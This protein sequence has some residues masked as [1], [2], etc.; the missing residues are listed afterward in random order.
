[1][2]SWVLEWAGDRKKY[3][4]ISLIL[5]VIHVVFRVM[6]FFMI[7]GIVNLFLDGN[8][9]ME[10]YLKYVGLIVVAYFLSELMHSLSTRMS[11]RATF[12][13]L[14]G[15]RRQAYEKLAKLPLGYVKSRSSGAIKTILVE[16]VDSMETLMAHVVPEFTSNI[17]APVIIM[18]YF[19]TI[20]YRMALA[21]LIPFGVGLFFAMGMS[22]G[23]GKYYNR[24]LTADKNL[25]AVS[26]EYIDGI[27]V[28]KAF[29][30]TK[31]SYEKFKVAAAEAANSC[32]DW[33]KHCIFYQTS[34]MVIMPFMLVAVLPFGGMFVA[35]GTLGTADFVTCVICS[36]SV[37]GPLVTV[38]SYIDDI[39][40]AS[41]IIADVT[42]ILTQPEL[43]RPE[44]SKSSPRDNSVSL[45]DV[46]FGYDEQEVLHGI[47]MDIKP[48]TVNALVGPSGTGKSTVAK[49]IASFWDVSSGS[50]EIG[51]VNIKDIA[52][53]DYNQKIAY[54]AQDNFLFNTSVRENIRQGKPDAT[55]EEVEEIAKKSG[56]YEFIMS[57]EK[58]FDTIAG[59]AG[60]HLSGG[61]RQR[62]SIARAMLK[63]AP[64]I[65]LDE[66]TAYTDPENEA[67]I[68]SSIAKLIAG[69]TLIVIAHRLSTIKDADQIFVINDGKLNAQGTHGELL[70]NCPLYKDMWEAHIQARD[71]KEVLA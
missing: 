50:I 1:M 27:E 35:N 25:D 17:L 6:P 67:I 31:A 51:G 47:T 56:C 42:Q 60:G 39:D 62:I 38:A 12:A 57:L 46:R 70:E 55:D 48:G 21:S 32:I 41:R 44:V 11:H 58:G 30:K 8:R 36:L 49:L 14:A 71:T 23:Y 53:R 52:L 15:I 13:T 22:I 4:V 69:K 63:D 18:V 61:E 34:A 66:A 33:M 29:S 43:D 3:F 19:F 5:A 26:V 7:G 28:I 54:V 65:I 16:R 20:D 10:A 59:G 9:Q 24:V 64:I 2:V 40:Q 68:Q 45:K 37:A